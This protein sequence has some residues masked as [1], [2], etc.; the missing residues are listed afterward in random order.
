MALFVCLYEAMDPVQFSEVANTASGNG[1][2]GTYTAL[3]PTTQC[4]AY[5]CSGSYPGV[6]SC[7]SY[8]WRN[9][10]T[11]FCPRISGGQVSYFGTASQS[12]LG[13]TCQTSSQ[14]Y[15]T[16]GPILVTDIYRDLVV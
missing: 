16:V 11:G 15:N 7:G 14:P 10:G 6:P 2:A 4:L 5:C 3:V 13:T 1:L 12:A 9:C 8:Q